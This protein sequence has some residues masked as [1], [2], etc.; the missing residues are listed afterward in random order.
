MKNRKLGTIEVHRKSD[1][2]AYIMIGIGNCSIAD[3]VDQQP[4]SICDI[5]LRLSIQHQKL[6]LSKVELLLQHLFH[7]NLGYK[8]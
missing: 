3:F 1:D 4:N 7:H 5:S 6:V 8:G 2:T